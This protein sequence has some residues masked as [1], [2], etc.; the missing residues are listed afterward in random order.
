MERKE[1]TGQIFRY[2]LYTA[3]VC[4]LVLGVTYARY[5]S[6]AAGTGTASVAVVALN[7][8]ADLSSELTKMTPGKNV[9]VPVSVSNVKE[10]KTSEVTQDYS[11]I[12]QTT[13]NLPLEFTLSPKNKNAD[14]TY[15]STVASPQSDNHSITWSGGQMKHSIITT[16]EYSLT[17]K[18]E[19]AEKDSAYADEID[20]ITLTVDAKQT[21]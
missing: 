19:D 3:L 4:S 21:Q 13:G 5:R 6:S 11:I 7:S 10:G 1:K 16:H 2:L 18:W 17:V 15:V 12:V 8:T 20:K 9:T 14:G